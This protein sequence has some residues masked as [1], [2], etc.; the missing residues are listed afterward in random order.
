MRV[1][2]RIETAF[3]NLLLSGLLSFAALICQPT[4]A[5][6]PIIYHSPELNLTIPNNFILLNKETFTT[7]QDKMEVSS[8]CDMFQEDEIWILNIETYKDIEDESTINYYIERHI[9][10][11]LRE[12]NSHEK[13]TDVIQALSTEQHNLKTIYSLDQQM[14]NGAVINLKAMIVGYKLYC[15]T[16]IKASNGDAEHGKQVLNRMIEKI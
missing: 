12:L 9:S 2:V 7:N 10:D 8:Y 15:F 5:A 4:F 14:Q 11:I 16:Y 1:T 3:R 6:N 13:V